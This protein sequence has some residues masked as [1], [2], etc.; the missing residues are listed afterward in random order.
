MFSTLLLVHRIVVSLFLLIYLVK[1]ILLLAGK[2]DAL[3]RFSKRIKVPEMI[4][5]AL[6]LLTGIYLAMN[7]G[8][9]SN[10]FW[11]KI[12]CIA[13][14]IPLAVMAY[15][16]LNKGLAV[17][18]LLLIVASYGLAE[19]NKKAGHTS[20]AEFS[21]VSSATLGKTI[22]DSKCANCHGPDGK[23][24]LSGAKDLTAST[25]TREEKID[26]IKKGKK[27]MMGFNDQLN[28]EQVSAVADYISSLK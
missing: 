4:C 1:T 14:A 28:E 23:M 3:A 2:N 17:F 13:A 19:M 18:S 7:S 12:I 27:A 21:N 5:S 16:K 20:P 25:L 10:L 9:I 15:K 26:I 6:F 11:I 24:G 22:F 8:N